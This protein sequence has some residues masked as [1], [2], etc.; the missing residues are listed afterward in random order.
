MPMKA[1]RVRL[2]DVTIEAVSEVAEEN[3]KSFAEIVRMCV[4]GQL[5]LYLSKIKYVDHDQGEEILKAVNRTA[6]ELEQIVSEIRRIG[7][8]YN[9]EIRLQNIRKKIEE[10]E[11]EPTQG[12]MSLVNKKREELAQLR[13]QQDSILKEKGSLN[14]SELVKLVKYAN[15]IVEKFGEDICRIAG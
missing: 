7:V 1:K 4:S 5:A 13:T 6:N 8:N 2:D 3:H 10:K 14:K 12:M 9:Q 15:G 11:S